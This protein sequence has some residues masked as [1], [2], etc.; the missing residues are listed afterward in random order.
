MEPSE[1]E[2][3]P[4]ISGTQTMVEISMSLDE[5][6]TKR[7]VMTFMDWLSQ[8]GGL[9]SMLVRIIYCIII[10]LDFDSLTKV[11]IRKLYFVQS[12]V[13]MDKNQIDEEQARKAFKSRERVSKVDFLS[14]FRAY[15]SNCFCCRLCKKRYK[16]THEQRIERKGLKKL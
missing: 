10:I 7:R 11:L 12:E 4:R 13:K 1:F 5:K 2:E 6:M 9:M 15:C 14:K 3:F 8:V 16:P